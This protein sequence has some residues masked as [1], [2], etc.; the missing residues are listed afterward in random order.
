MFSRVRGPCMKAGLIAVG[1]E[2]L[3][4]TVQNTNGTDLSQFLGE[5]GISVLYHTVVGDNPLRLKKVIDQ[6][7]AEVDMLVITGGLGPTEDDMT[8]ET[9]CEHLGIDLV[10]D[11]QVKTKLENFFK[12]RSL[13]MPLNNKK[14]ALCPKGAVI[15]ENKVGTAPGFIIETLEKV[16][17]LLP[18]PPSE[19][20]AM[21]ENGLRTYLMTTNVSEITSVWIRIFGMG[22]SMVEDKLKDLFQNQTMPTLATYVRQGTVAVRLTAS[23][24]TQ[25]QNEKLILPVVKEIVSRLGSVVYALKDVQLSEVVASL[26]IEKNITVSTA[27]SCTGGLLASELIDKP[28]ISKIFER[29]FV[30]Y[31]NQAKR[32]ELNVKDSLL[33]NYGAVSHQVAKAMVEGLFQKSKSSLCVSITGIAGPEGGTVE[34]PVGLVYIGILYRGNMNVYCHRLHGKRNAIRRRSVL[35]ALFH[36]KENIEKTSMKSHLDLT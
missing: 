17:V 21:I 15:L 9:V 13:Q 2:L 25:S 34:K 4:G 24:G 1:T 32:E 3:M 27:E 20:K 5:R 14:Q 10:L 18:G 35:W 22:E 23:G 7:L 28:G 6:L 26:C 36:M 33:M 31:S 12:E 30:T 29:G 16:V 11:Y 19:M 8:K